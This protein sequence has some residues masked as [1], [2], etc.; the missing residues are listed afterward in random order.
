MSRD[1]ILKMIE[2]VLYLRSVMVYEIRY[3]GE[4]LL[5]NMESKKWETYGIRL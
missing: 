1:R 3:M 4:D 2:K 5:D